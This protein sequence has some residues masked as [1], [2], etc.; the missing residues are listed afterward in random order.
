[1]YSSKYCSNSDAR[2][3][4]VMGMIKKLDLTDADIA[5]LS[6]KKN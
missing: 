2:E 4:V 5:T 1:M 6:K 3:N